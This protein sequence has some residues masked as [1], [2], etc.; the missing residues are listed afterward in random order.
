MEEQQ[1]RRS[2]QRQTPVDFPLRTADKIRYG[3]TDRQGHV[4]NAVYAS[5]FETGRMELLYGERMDHSASYVIARISIDFIAEAQ[6]PGSVEIGT[7]VSGFGRTSFRLQQAV[8]QEARMV[9]SAESV[10]VHVDE[11]SGRPSPLSSAT[12]QLL[13]RFQVMRQSL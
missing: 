3:D 13:S 4:N 5:F 2:A 10:V 7:R 8:F 11:V 6:W 1:G 12:V 9:A